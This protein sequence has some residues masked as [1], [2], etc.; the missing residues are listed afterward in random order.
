MLDTALYLM[1]YPEPDTIFGTTYQRLGS[2]KGVGMLGDW[3]WE[4]FSVEDMA[5]GMM[6][7][8]NGSSL[9]LES[10]FA[11]NMEKHEEMSVSLMGDKGGADVF[12]LKIYQEK[13]ETLVDITP[14]YLPSKNK[15]ELEIE[16]FVRNCRAG[17]RQSGTALDGVKLQ[18]IINGLY[19]SAEKEMPIKLD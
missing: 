6:T 18:K 1:G 9:I 14:S 2:K 10:A 3:D 11:A 16:H 19:E 7:F 4:N 15:Y 12:P 8:Q 5:R 13:H 17:K